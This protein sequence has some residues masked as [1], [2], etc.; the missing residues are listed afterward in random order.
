MRVAVFGV[1]VFA[2]FA[3]LASAPVGAADMKAPGALAADVRPVPPPG[4]CVC[5]REYRPVCGRLPDGT[6]RTFPNACTAGCAGAVVVRPG[7]C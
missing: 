7:K 6:E 3:V 2:V 5:T 4:R 1:A